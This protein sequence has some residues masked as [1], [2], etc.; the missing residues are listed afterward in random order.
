M[1]NIIKAIFVASM[2]NPRTILARLGLRFQTFVPASTLMLAHDQLSE[3]AAI[4]K[5]Y[6]EKSFS[7]Y[8]SRDRTTLICFPKAR[9]LNKLV[10]VSIFFEQNGI[11]KRDYLHTYTFFYLDWK[12]L[13]SHIQLAK[14]VIDKPI[15]TEPF[16]ASQQIFNI[17]ALGNEGTCFFDYRCLLLIPK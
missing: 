4:W 13:D 2:L 6:Q 10:D 17:L 3:C 14:K 5:Q 12:S 16:V 11:D 15:S 1:K 7:N 8:L 9:V